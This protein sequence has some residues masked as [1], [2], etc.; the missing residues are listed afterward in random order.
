MLLY[1]EIKIKNDKMKDV[2]FMI[3]LLEL[4]RIFLLHKHVT[5]GLLR[6]SYVLFHA[7]ERE[8]W[9]VQSALLFIW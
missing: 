4:L 3:D 2:K 5:A 8:V 6:S 9:G 1:V 7:V